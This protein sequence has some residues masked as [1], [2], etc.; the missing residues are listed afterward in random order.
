[1]QSVFQEW[2]Q[3]LNWVIKNNGEYYFE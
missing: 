3:R 2:M 1:L